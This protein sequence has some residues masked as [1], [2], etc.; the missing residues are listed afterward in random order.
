MEQ[1]AHPRK[2][3]HKANWFA[4]HKVITGI[5]LVVLF[6]LTGALIN[7]S[8]GNNSTATIHPSPTT[9]AERQP[10]PVPIE[11]LMVTKQPTAT[12]KPGPLTEKI[13]GVLPQTMG[14]PDLAV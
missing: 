1:H 2:P 14:S 8:S 6:G 4:N 10:T 7:H 12:P 13:I 9:V 3:T 5:F 11:N